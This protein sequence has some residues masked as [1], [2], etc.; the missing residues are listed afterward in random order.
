MCGFTVLVK[1]CHYHLVIS[2]NCYCCNGSGNKAT[3]HRTVSM[4]SNVKVCNYVGQ[5]HLCSPYTGPPFFVPILTVAGSSIMSSGA[6]QW[7]FN[8]EWNSTDCNLEYVIAVDP[9]LPTLPSDNCTED[10]TTQCRTYTL[11]RDDPRNFTVIAQNCGGTQNGSE[12]EPIQL[13]FKC[14]FACMII[15]VGIKR[16]VAVISLNA[17]IPVAFLASFSYSDRPRSV[18]HCI[19]NAVVRYLPCGLAHC[20]HCIF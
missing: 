3:R 16:T 18:A 1:A 6:N 20:A 8:L 4:T 10:C 11:G 5:N 2:H 13:C 7:E 15:L 9:P 12:S 19:S 14:K 17:S